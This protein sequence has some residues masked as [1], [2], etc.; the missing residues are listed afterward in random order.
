MSDATLVDCERHAV[1]TDVGDL[2]PHLDAASALRLTQGEFKLPPLGPHP[3]V[4]IEGRTL[5]GAGDPA[6]AAAALGPD[7]AAALLVPS[8]PLTSSG[9]LNHKIAQTFASAVNDH[10]LASWIP[11]DDRFRLALAVQPHDPEMAAEEIRRVGAHP[12]VAAVSLSLI[13]VNMGQRHYHPIYAAASELGLPVIVHPGGFEGSV[14]GPAELG[15]V[16]PY[17]AE[18]GF[19]LIP[20][21]AMANLSSIVYDGVFERFPDLKV[22]FAGFG[23]AWAVSLLW[24]ADAEF[25]NLR[26][27]VPWLTRPPSEYVAEH[28]RFVVDGA[29]EVPSDIGWRLAEMLPESLLL[30]GSDAPFLT[31]SPG[32]ALAGM[33]EALAGGVLAGNARATFRLNG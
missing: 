9:W 31:R 30:Y 20:Q 6:R 5:E 19:S 25:R 2:V 3:G 8:Q 1:V 24:R 23:F 13:R 4:E 21:M 10:V 28:V 33:P 7:V 29:G 18:E 15:G 16:G 14:V 27:E 22:V 32:E 12:K 17:T 26:I 11:A